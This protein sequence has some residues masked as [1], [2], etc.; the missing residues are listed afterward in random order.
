MAAVGTMVLG[1]GAACGSSDTKDT[2]GGDGSSGGI[3]SS[4]SASGSETGTGSADGTDSQASASASASASATAATTETS[5]GSAESVGTGPKFDLGIQPDFAGK[6]CTMG[7]GD[8]EFSFLWAANS[9]QGTISKIDTQTVTEVGRFI[10]RPDSAGNPSRTS[11]NLEGDVAVANRSGGVTKIYALEE[12]CQESN[13]SPGI[14]TSTD[15]NFLAWGEEECIAWHTPF[16]YESQRPVA[17]TQGT[18]NEDLCEY[19]DVY[20][21]TSGRVGQQ[22]D[23]LLLDGED[24]AVVDM[25]TLAGFPND[26]YG[27]YGGAVDGEGN[28]WGTKLGGVML[29]RVDI[30]DLEYTTWPVPVSSYGMTVDSDG[31]VWACSSTFGRFDPMTETWMTGNGGGYAGCM[32]EAGD[33]GLVWMAGGAGVIGID[34]QTLLPVANWP[35]PGSYGVSIDYYGYVWTVAYGDGAHRIDKVTG[36]VTSYYGLVGAYTYSDMTGYAL[37]HAGGGAPSG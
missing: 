35:T 24:G 17:W 30:D 28:F 36:T 6:P 15:S 23:V 37:T 19:E 4:A 33:D 14:Q 12:R 31:Y 26:Y 22:T 20:L 34:R 13:G 7:G 16:N 25:V 8:P 10:V 3:G 1:L 11:V 21:W 9:T 29:V 18:F 27:I 2:G 5:N 32:A